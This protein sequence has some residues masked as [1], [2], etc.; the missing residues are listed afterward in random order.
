M[1]PSLKILTIL[2]MTAVLSCKQ[3]KK[4]SPVTPTV[5][6]QQPTTPATGPDVPGVPQEVMIKLLNE[7]TFVDYIF[8]DLPFSLSQNE[9]PSIDQNISYIDFSRPVGKLPSNCKATARKFFQIRGEI[10]YDVDVYLGQGC[11]YYVFVDKKNKPIYANYL[12]PDG[13]KFYFN[14]INQAVGGIQKK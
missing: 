8:H 7:C 6:T 4:E 10:V 2:A 9:D 3:E 5:A 14:I 13:V 11:N 12:T 1:L